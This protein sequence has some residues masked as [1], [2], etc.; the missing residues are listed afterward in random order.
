[1]T[2]VPQRR[3]IPEETARKR[4]FGGVH[5]ET[6]RRLRVAGK[7]KF[8]RIGRNVFYDPRH[9]DEFLAGREKNK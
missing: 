1:M 8:Y 5:K 7:L 4:Y 3:G 9:I 6:L 2:K